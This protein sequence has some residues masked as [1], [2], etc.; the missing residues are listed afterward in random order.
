TIIAAITAAERTTAAITTVVMTAH[1]GTITGCTGITPPTTITP[2]TMSAIT[3]IACTTTQC[4]ITTACTCT[5]RTT[6]A[7]TTAA[8]PGRAGAGATAT[9]AARAITGATPARARC[10]T[11]EPAR[12]LT[13]SGPPTSLVGVEVHSSREAR[14][15]EG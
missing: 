7:A 11:Y 2:A 4:T 6:A 14:D 12:R 15:G 10:R 1:D 13:V 8:G 3:R 5:T 9:G